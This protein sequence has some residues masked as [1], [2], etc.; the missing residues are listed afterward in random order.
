MAVIKLK[1]NP[2][3]TS[4]ELPAIGSRAKDFKFVKNDLS[5]V[6]LESISTKY[7][8]LNIFPSIDTGTCAMSVR[9]FNKRMAE[10][11]EA[12]VVCLSQDLPFAL[13][14]FCG[15]EGIDKV[16]TGSLFRSSFAKEYGLEMTDG[17][18]KGLCSR[19]VIILDN[20]NKVLY[21]EQV[22]DIVNEPDY[23]KALAA[24]RS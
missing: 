14:R 7:R 21:T 13:G 2:I 11:P 4:G 18:L 23:E 20:E 10:H 24:L 5:E 22:A 16:V 15:A 8:I 6:G 17:P 9:Q 19:V 1:G 12:T 3:H